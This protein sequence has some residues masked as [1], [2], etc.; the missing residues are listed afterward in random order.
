VIGAQ[1]VRVVMMGTFRHATEVMLVST[2][3][4]TAL[5]HRADLHLL[6]ALAARTAQVIP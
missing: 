5:S 1:S 3:F 4:G 2:G 6:N